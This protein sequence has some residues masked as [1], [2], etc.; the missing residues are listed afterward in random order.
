MFG[1]VPALQASKGDVH[2]VMKQ[3][4]ADSR[5][6]RGWLRGM[7]IGAQM[8]LCTMLLIPAGL[9]SRALYA[10]HTFDPGF[11]QRNVAAGLDRSARSPVRE[12]QRRDLSRAVAR[13]CQGVARRRACR[14]GEPHAVEPRP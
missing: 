6:G 7:L 9:L 11:D 12:G 5:G 3:D 4:G 1:L 2:A 10:A 13:T 14:A 8:A